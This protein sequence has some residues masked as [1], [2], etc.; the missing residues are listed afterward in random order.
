MTY[1]NYIVYVRIQKITIFIACLPCMHM[2]NNIVLY[3]MGC[4]SQMGTVKRDQDSEGVEKQGSKGGEI[5]KPKPSRGTRGSRLGSVGECRKLP[6][7]GLGRAQV[8]NGFCRI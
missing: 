2:V 6:Q 7:Q 1:R 5:E 3:K 4:P 8:D